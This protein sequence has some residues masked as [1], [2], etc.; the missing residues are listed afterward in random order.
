M[1]KKVS[2]LGC[3]WLGFPLAKKL[4]EL[5]YSVNG[6]T[7]KIEKFNDLK[8]AGITPFIVNLRPAENDIQEFIDTD[9]LIINI[10]PRN[11]NGDDLF[12]FKQVNFIKNEVLKKK[13]LKVIFISSTSVYP[14]LKREVIEDDASYNSTSRAGISLLEIEDL[15][16]HHENINCTVIR[17]SGLIGPKRHPGRFFSNEKIYNGGEMPVNL[18]HQ[19]DCIGI[20]STVIA[21][22]IWN[23]RFN[24][25]CPDHP[26]KSNFYSMAARSINLTPPQFNN[27]EMGFKIINSDKLIQKTGY[28]FKFSKLI[29]AI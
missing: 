15:F 29:D 14:E 27:N 11:K 8:K 25:S 23:E 17:F 22:N 20:I 4:I 24:A 3:G 21:K 1:N 19:E 13:G 28:Q 9:I 6:S 16:M 26:T 18:I 2:V 10:P 12:H 5:G 7:T